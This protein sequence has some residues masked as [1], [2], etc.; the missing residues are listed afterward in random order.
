MKRNEDSET[1]GTTIIFYKIKV[2]EFLKITVI[3]QTVIIFSKPIIIGTRL[4][5]KKVYS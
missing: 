2:I 5:Q 3:L 4:P 1:S